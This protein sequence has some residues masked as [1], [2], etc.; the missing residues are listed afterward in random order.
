MSLLESQ[1]GEIDTDP[2]VIYFV[3]GA[4]ISSAEVEFNS[5]QFSIR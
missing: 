4:V 3:A 2:H 1:D 5:F